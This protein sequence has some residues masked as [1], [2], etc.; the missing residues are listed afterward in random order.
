M[1]ETGRGGIRR[2]FFRRAALGFP[3]GALLVHVIFVV[4]GAFAYPRPEGTAVPVVT[5]AMAEA[6]G[7]PVTAALVQLIWSGLFGAALAT[8][9]IPFL[10]ER[11]L[12]LWSS[13]H[14][15]ATAAVF[16][17]AGWQCRWFP[18]RSTWLCL[19]GLLLLCYILR[20][21]IRFLE[22]QSDVRALRKSAG[23]DAREPPWKTLAPYLLLAAAVELLLP[24][25]LM[26]VDAVDVPVLTGMFYPFLILPL[27]SFISACSL[28]TRLP[29]WWLAYPAVCMVLTLPC[30]AL[31]YNSTALF[32]AWM[33]GIPA[34]AG[35]LLGALLRKAKKS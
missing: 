17:L 21:S 26:L 4:S 22:W 12:L 18:Y 33:T 15:L 32:Q 19:S 24:P 6:F 28:G 31:I 1:N 25:G 14:F 8:A 29:R 11:R 7:N 35:G 34:L 30:I 16:T 23:L 9:R 2:E 5:A 13:L 27:F 3:W 10:L 20:W